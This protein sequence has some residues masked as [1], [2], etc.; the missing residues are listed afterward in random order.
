LIVGAVLHRSNRKRELTMTKSILTPLRHSAGTLTGALLATVLAGGAAFAATAGTPP[1]ITAMSQKLKG[2]SVSITYA[3][4]PQKGTLDIYA[5][6]A[7]GKASATPLGK[8][9]LEAG[10]HRDIDVTLSRTPKK[11]ERLRAVLETSGK[12]FKNA[13]DLADRTFKVLG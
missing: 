1:S 5:V 11:G 8:V 6:N 13:G 9:A 2:D 4:M 7:S 12:P 10:D 3:F